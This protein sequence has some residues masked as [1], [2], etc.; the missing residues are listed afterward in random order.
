MEGL[1]KECRNHKEGG[2]GANSFLTIFSKN[3]F[4]K[5]FNTHFGFYRKMI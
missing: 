4:K 1:K 5:N 2:G 3:I